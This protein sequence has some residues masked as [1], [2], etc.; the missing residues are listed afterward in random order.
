MA[1][2]GKAKA[3]KR[4]VKDLSPRSAKGKSV[5]GGGAKSANNLKQIGLAVHN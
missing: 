2:K 1:R 5:K 3:R 4:S